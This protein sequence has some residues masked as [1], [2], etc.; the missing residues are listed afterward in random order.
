MLKSGCC[1]CG[2]L[3]D[4]L[5]P[6]GLVQTGV[7]ANIRRAH[8]LHG[9]LPDFLNGTRG[10]LL[11]GAAGQ[12]MSFSKTYHLTKDDVPQILEVC[13]QNLINKNSFKFSHYNFI[14]VV[15]FLYAIHH[16]PAPTHQ[17]QLINLFLS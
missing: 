9:E 3:P 17:I 5:S 8:L 11:E 7:D 10:S 15:K 14:H 16:G 4:S 2:A 12:T 13:F 1:G 6:H